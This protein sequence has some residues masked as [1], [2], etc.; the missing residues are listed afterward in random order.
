VAWWR[1]PVTT[2]PYRRTAYI[3]T[4]PLADPL[5][6][7]LSFASPDRAAQLQQR[8]AAGLL[9]S[10]GSTVRA[11]AGRFRVSSWLVVVLVVDLVVFGLTVYLWLLV[12]SNVAYP[13]R[14]G[15]VEYETAWGGPTLA[16]AWLLHAAAGLIFLLIIPWLLSAMTKIQARSRRPLWTEKARI[17]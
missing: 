2:D 9:L 17:R 3:L 4:A 11:A 12:A 5:S 14:P 13:L 1:R 6:L 16:G 8:V 7:L 10:P 15:G